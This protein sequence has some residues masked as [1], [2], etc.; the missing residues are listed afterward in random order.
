MDLLPSASGP[1]D[2]AGDPFARFMVYDD[3]ASLVYADADDRSQT[4]SN[5]LSFDPSKVTVPRYLLYMQGILLGVVALASFLLGILTGGSAARIGEVHEPMPC[6]ISGRVALR[7]QN[8]DTLPDPGAVAMVFPQEMRPESRFELI[9]LRSRDPE[10][11]DDH[12]TLRAIRSLGGDYARADQHG[13]F[14]LRV[15]DR[16]KYFVLVISATRRRRADDEM[17]RQVR[18]ELGRFFQLEPEMFGGYDYRWQPETVRSDR[19]LSFLF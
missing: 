7:T 14:R 6:V 8:D 13:V 4:I 16:G 12:P 15:P 19:Q 18:A 17:P 1:I 5:E 3:D 9:G 2:A 10:P 11:T